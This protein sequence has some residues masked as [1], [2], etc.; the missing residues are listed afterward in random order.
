MT[1]LVG[2]AYQHFSWLSNA[3]IKMLYGGNPSKLRDTLE[4]AGMRIYPE[5]YLSLVGFFLIISIAASLIA[6]WLTGFYLIAIVPIIT[7]LI[8][9]ALPAVKA[10]DRASKLDMEAPFMAAYVSVMATGGLS[11]YSSMK[12]LKDCD[13][14]PQTS[15]MAKQIE[16]DVL[17]KGMDPIAAI[18]KS[19]GRAPSREYREFFLGYVQT[20]RAGGDVVHYLLTR[21]ET[22][23]RDLTA[24]MKIFGERAA[25]F[26][27]S[28]V[29]I[30]ILGTLGIS[31]VYLVSIAFRGYWQGG[32]TAENFL[33]Y[34]YIL[35]P[36]ISA[37]FIYLSDLS[38]FQE[39]I[40]ETAPY[41]VYMASLPIMMFLVFTMFLPYLI[42]GLASVPL[43]SQFK[44]FLTA[45][46]SML[47]LEHGV[48]PSLGMGIALIAGTIPAAIAHSYYERRR[49]R[50]MIREVANFL[51]DM[52]ETR[53]TGASPEA[54]IIQLSLRPYGPFSK[55]LRI[56]ARQLKWGRPV[57]VVYETLKKKIS[58]WFSLMN[59]YLLVDAIEIGG[60]S[61]ETLET[62]AKFG[63]MQVSIEKERRASLRPL[64]IMPYIGSVLMVFSTL[65]TIS[66]MRS[67]V[68]TI[69]RVAIPFTHILTIILPAL[70]F[71]SYMMGIVT[72]KI[73]TGNI[74][75]GFS[76]AIMLTLVA[77]IS[78]ISMQLFGFFLSFG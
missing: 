44:N 53:K 43:V 23:F 17:L 61:P 70:V 45:L 47:G 10:Q 78:I 29:A 18:E 33:L 63:E 35:V 14:L 7:L 74:S 54:C 32:F 21:T 16:V 15:K 12:R 25:V 69:A 72:G 60:G 65:V 38:S 50:R 20:L 39:P 34:S 5:A 11:P 41:K 55:Y 40:Y 30:M 77:I 71:Q 1:S 24:K 49:G 31:I 4:T 67:A 52:T 36:V 58:S 13:L 26:L 3:L 22:M 66:F 59:I 73:S 56:V 76:H 62:M 8:G 42:H 19:A 68:S 28:Y 57:R 9:Y 27:E 48:E 6:I 46:R 2:F 37:L 75:A 64:V 51:R